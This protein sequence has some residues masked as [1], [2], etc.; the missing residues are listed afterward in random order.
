MLRYATE[1]EAYI[2]PLFFALLASLN[3]VRFLKEKNDRFA[4]YA[5][6]FA[7]LAVLF[8]QTYIFWW[9]GLLAAFLNEKGK[10]ASSY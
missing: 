2:V 9:A 5:G 1:N 7:S 6:L 3:W 10:R 8:H 4:L